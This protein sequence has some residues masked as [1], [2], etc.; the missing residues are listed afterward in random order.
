MLW[1]EDKK[2][3]CYGEETSL[4][5]TFVGSLLVG[6]KVADYLAATEIKAEAR[7]IDNHW[8]NYWA[9]RRKS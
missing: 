1:P 9:P 3:E 7:S 8:Y 2:I 6:L 5:K 4:F